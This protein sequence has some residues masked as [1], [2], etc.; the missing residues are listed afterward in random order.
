MISTFNFNFENNE[1]NAIL[2]IYIFLNIG[3][4]VWQLACEFNVVQAH[5]AQTLS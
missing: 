3:G 1:S 4:G 2:E 5:L